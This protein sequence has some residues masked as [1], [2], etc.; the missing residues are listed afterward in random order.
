MS[1]NV[2][3]VILVGDGV[4]GLFCALNPVTVLTPAPI[5]RDASSSWAQDGLAAA[6]TI[7]AEAAHTS[8]ASISAG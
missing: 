4:A 3:D 7:A 1:D 6:R 8:H 2:H 5:C